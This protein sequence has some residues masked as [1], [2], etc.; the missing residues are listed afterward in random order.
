MLITFLDSRLQYQLNLCPLM[1]LYPILFSRDQSTEGRFSILRTILIC[2]KMK[3]YVLTNAPSWSD[4]VYF[5]NA[6]LKYSGE[7]ISHIPWFQKLHVN[8]F[9]QRRLPSATSD[10]SA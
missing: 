5:S 10:L 2:A 1:H 6:L 9:I 4:K 7:S 3:W 8:G